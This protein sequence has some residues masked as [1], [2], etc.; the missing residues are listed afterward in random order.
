[1]PA[2]YFEMGRLERTAQERPPLALC[3]RAAEGERS[4]IDHAGLE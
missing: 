3:A 1:M 4:S 2:A